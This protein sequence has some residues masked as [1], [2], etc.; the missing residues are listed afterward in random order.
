MKR[1]GTHIWIVGTQT[2]E[3]LYATGDLTVF[4]PAQ[5]SL[6][7]Y[8]CIAPFSGARI[9]TDGGST[10]L[11][12]LNQS[13]RGGGLTVVAAGL[14]PKNI[15]TYAITQYEQARTSHMVR[16]RC[17]GM[18]IDGHVEY[19]LNNREAQFDL[20]PVFDFTEGIWH[21][22]AHW[23]TT[24]VAWIPWRAQCHMYFDQR[25]WVGDMLTGALYTLSM[26]NLTDTLVTV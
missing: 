21:N 9:E 24:T 10:T 22:R 8:G 2:S 6:I 12:W 15:S 7:E 14:T 26:D 19:V 13:E 17:F 20:T 3:V 1:N 11:A 16:A 25:H 23:N 5:E 18:Q 4:A